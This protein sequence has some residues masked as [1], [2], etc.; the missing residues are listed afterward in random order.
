M[1]ER[2]QNLVTNLL[3]NLFVS[4]VLTEDIIPRAVS[5]ASVPHHFR[6][7]FIKIILCI[8]ASFSHPSHSP[9]LTK[10]GLLLFYT[11]CYEKLN[12]Y[13]SRSFSMSN[14]PYVSGVFPTLHRG[15]LEIL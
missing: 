3:R 10:I 2:I 7:M 8:Y 11:R 13:N 9:I 15:N 4:L 1:W 6:S 5:P 14:H 12:A